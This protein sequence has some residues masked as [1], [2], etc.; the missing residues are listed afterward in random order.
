MYQGP[1]YSSVSCP[2][3]VFSH[4]AVIGFRLHVRYHHP[5][6]RTEHSIHPN[7]STPQTT[8]MPIDLASKDVSAM[9]LRSSLIEIGDLKFHGWAILDLP[10][11]VV[12]H[13]GSQFTAQPPA[14]G[15]YGEGNFEIPQG[16]RENVVN[17]QILYLYSLELNN[18]KCFPLEFSPDVVKPR[19]LSHGISISTSRRLPAPIT[20]SRCTHENHRNMQSAPLKF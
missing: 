13:F 6:L 17:I 10:R 16:C 11:P 4:C 2:S 5:G 20:W 7:M 12:T 1:L 9:D 18:F 8:S 15:Y 3:Q 19:S 14:P